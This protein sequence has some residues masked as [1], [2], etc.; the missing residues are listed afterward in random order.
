MKDCSLKLKIFKDLTNF[1]LN[2]EKIA[3]KFKKVYS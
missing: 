3:K 1:D 2:E